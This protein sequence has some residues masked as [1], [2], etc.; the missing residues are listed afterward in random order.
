MQAL[1]DLIYAVEGSVSE[2]AKILGYIIFYLF[3][4]IISIFLWTI[5]FELETDKMILFLYINAF[6]EEYD[7]HSFMR[8]VTLMSMDRFELI[9]QKK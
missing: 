6:L 5:A 4:Y 2:A 1:L 3:I 7:M 8:C 9:W